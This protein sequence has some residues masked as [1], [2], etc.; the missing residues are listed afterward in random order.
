MIGFIVNPVA[1]MGGRVGLKGTDG[2]VEEAIKRGA[3][4]VSPHIAREFLKSLRCEPEFLTVSDGMGEDFLRDFGLSY[5]LVYSIGEGESTSSEDTKKACK[6]MMEKSDLI[7]FIGGDGTARDIASV[8][9][10]RVPVIGI[11]SGVKMYSSC[12]AIT[13]EKGAELLCEFLKGNCA[14]KDAEVLDIDE[15]AYRNG[16]LSISLYG[17]VMIPYISEMVQDSKKEYFGDERSSKEEIAEYMVENMEPDTLYIIGAGSTTAK[18]AEKMGL[19]KTILGIDAYYNGEIVGKDLSEM[20]ILKLLDRYSK[21]KIIVSPIGAQGFIFG[22]GN[23]QISPEVIRK[24]GI[25]NI[26][27]VA[28]PQ[29][30]RETPE[31]HVYTGD[32]DTDSRFMGHIRVLSGYGRYTVKRVT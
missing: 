14:L 10:D 3:K 21:A 6:I 9:G 15:N 16:K 27:V 12:F 18:I 20:E 28:T 17:H 13:P 22:R 23:Q 19:E 4:P 29:K 2:M 5:E 7:V 30:L 26:I 1:G 8:L 24:V 32:E 11:P 25:E 31:L